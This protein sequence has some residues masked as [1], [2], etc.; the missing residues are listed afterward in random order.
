MVLLT[1]TVIVSSF[2]CRAVFVWPGLFASQAGEANDGVILLK[3]SKLLEP[4][5]MFKNSK[6][7]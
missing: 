1:F 6:N 3:K 7:A 2:G 4:K 5:P